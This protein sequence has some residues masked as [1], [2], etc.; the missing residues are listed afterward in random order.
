MNHNTTR[1][2]SR[3]AAAGV[4]AA[5]LL[6]GLITGST[7]LDQQEPATSAESPFLPPPTVTD[8]GDPTP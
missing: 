7:L 2:W 5:A 8:G 1:R 3:P 4:A 6:A